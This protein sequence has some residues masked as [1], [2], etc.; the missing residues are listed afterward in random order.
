[1]EGQ[2][3]QQ[4]IVIVCGVHDLHYRIVGYFC[5]EEIFAI[6]RVVFKMQKYNRDNLIEQ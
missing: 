2:R 4:N 1:M 3:H 6:L 5:E